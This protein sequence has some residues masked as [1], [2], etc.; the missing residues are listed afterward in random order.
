MVAAGLRGILPRRRQFKGGKKTRKLK[1]TTANTLA[2]EVNNQDQWS[3]PKVS[4]TKSDKKK[5]F[6]MVMAC[7]VQIFCETQVYSW[8][9]KLYKQVKGLPI[10]P[11][12]TSC[13]ARIVMNALDEMVENKLEKLNIELDLFIRYMD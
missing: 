12:A 5:I 6:S 8:R 9:G 11:R 10:G 7:M 4:L 1:L 3:W 2:P 13:I